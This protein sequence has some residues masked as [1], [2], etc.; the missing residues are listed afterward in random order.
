[1]MPTH[2]S[3]AFIYSRT[4]STVPSTPPITPFHSVSSRLVGLIGLESNI[5]IPSFI[6]IELPNFRLDAIGNLHPNALAK[7]PMANGDV[8]AVQ[9]VADLLV[10]AESRVKLSALRLQLIA[11]AVPKAG[12]LVANKANRHDE[13]K[14]CAA[15]RS[16]TSIRCAAAVR[17]QLCAMPSLQ[18][19]W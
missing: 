3:S 1:M 15:S 8:V 6:W 7:G 2:Q 13:I 9:V 18:F 14:M 11:V 12:T 10:V 19:V 4:I 17:E 16:G 5:S